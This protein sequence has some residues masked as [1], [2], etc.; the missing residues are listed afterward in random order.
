[1]TLNSLPP[2]VLVQS[3]DDYVKLTRELASQARLAVDTESNSLHAYHE[4]VCLIQ[5]STPR[6]DYILDPL[7]F[8]DLS[9]LAPIF[10][11]P[12]IQKIFHAS[13]YDIICL[14][15]DYGFTF[16]NIF[17]TMQAGRILGRKQAGLDRLLDD[18]FGIKV[19]K[20]FQ[21]ADWGVRPL[22]R[23]ALSH[24]VERPAQGRT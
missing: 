21:K 20:R 7:A 16:S 19:N 12:H 2:P 6:Q 8:D 18:K 24:P 17:D 13:E 15:R 14:S 3:Y 11:N 9:E 10:D 5:F 1:M 23:D 22:S 4:R